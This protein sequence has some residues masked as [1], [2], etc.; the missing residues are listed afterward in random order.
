MANALLDSRTPAQVDGREQHDEADGDLDPER[1]ELGDRRDDVVD[2]RGDRHRD[3]EDVVDEQGGRDDD[4]GALA[5]VLAGD[6]VVAAAARVR[7]DELAVGRDDDEQE[8]HD[9]RRRPRARSCRNASPPTSR[10]I[11]SSCGA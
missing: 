11:R 2:A 4:A 1:V 7:L 10:I 5:D 6:L 3:G 9:R 8:Q